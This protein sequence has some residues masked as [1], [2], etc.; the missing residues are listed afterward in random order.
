MQLEISEGADARRRTPSRVR[1]GIWLAVTGLLIATALAG[2]AY[3]QYVLKP[4]LIQKAISSSPQPPVTITAEPAQAATWAGRL[5]SIGTLVAFAGVDVSSQVGGVVAAIRFENGASVAQ[6]QT[7]VQLDDSI[8]RADLASNQATLLQA[9][10]NFARQED[11]AAK[12]VAA[13]STLESA[14]ATRDSSAA[15][16]QRSQALVAQ[17]EIRAPFAGRIGIRKIDVGQYVS[18]GMT[19]VTL[20]ALDPM[21][22][23]FTIP[24]RYIPDVKPGTTVELTVDAYPG[25]IFK[26]AVE[27]LDSRVDPSTRALLVRASV[28]NP[29]GKL[30][31]GMFAD[32]T[33]SIGRPEDVVTVPRTAVS[34]SLY[35]DTVYVVPARR[36]GVGGGAADN[37]GRGGTGQGG[38]GEKGVE[39]RSV[40]VG[41]A[42]GDRVAILE[43]VVAG[44][45]VV[46]SGQLK[47]QPGAHVRIDNSA[48]LKP[49]E[50]RPRE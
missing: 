10:L 41:D 6:G 45:T 29:D 8:E 24:E 15:A 5:R 39:R 12:G 20:Q 49:P 34:Y 2:L 25:Q 13:Q 43:G 19:L 9:Q 37:D 16:V 14:R 38:A 21:R 7:L 28:A 31:A 27:A 33:V 18:P 50:Q 1:R 23:D 11:L 17:K 22:V 32:I 30:L 47:L 4:A 40:R 26:G 42:R 36:G 3:F 48:S 44:E 46:T 35:G